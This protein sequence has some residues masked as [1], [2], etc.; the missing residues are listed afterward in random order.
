MKKVLIIGGGFAGCANAHALSL[1]GEY[2]ITLVE[3]SN[4]LG[5]GVRT[6]FW[7]GHPYTF[8]PRHFLTKDQKLYDF[9]NKYVPMRDCSEHKYLTYV[10]KDDQ[11]YS[12][13]LSYDDIELMPDKQQIY[14]ELDD[15]KKN[16]SNQKPE[17]LEDFWISSIG[18]IL[19]KKV[20]LKILLFSPEVFGSPFF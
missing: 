11:F 19:Y 18:K 6:H 14:N 9:L 10:E 12:M 1:T 7:G 16:P 4:Q 17:N 20:V 2:E 5:A 8:G 15:I 13:P 3:K